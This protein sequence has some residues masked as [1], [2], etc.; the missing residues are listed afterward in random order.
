M[1]VRKKNEKIPTQSTWASEV[2]EDELSDSLHQSESETYTRNEENETESNGPEE[3][4]A[5][6]NIQE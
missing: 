1:T 2:S 4:A 6:H 5:Q 3:D